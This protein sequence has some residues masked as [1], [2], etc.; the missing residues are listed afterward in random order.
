MFK[1]NLFVHSAGRGLDQRSRLMLAV[2]SLPSQRSVRPGETTACRVPQ[3]GSSE[4]FFS[5]PLL[6]R[7]PK[8][9]SRWIDCNKFYSG[10][11]LR[12][13]FYLPFD[14]TLKLKPGQIVTVPL[15][16]TTSDTPVISGWNFKNVT[17]AQTSLFRQ[18]V[19]KPKLTLRVQPCPFS[20]LILSFSSPFLLFLSLSFASVIFIFGFYRRQKPASWPL[21]FHSNGYGCKFRQIRFQKSG[22]IYNGVFRHQVPTLYGP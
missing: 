11:W 14:S 3:S 17:A 15:G 6:R 22:Q 12:L 16:S 21:S 1:V 4:K 9:V 7:V 18:A 8:L 13:L 19:K 10:I 2:V 5:K 20:L